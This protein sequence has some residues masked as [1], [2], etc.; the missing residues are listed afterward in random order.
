[1]KREEIKAIFSDATDEQ[2][3]AVLDLNGAD[4][5]KAKGKATALEA[6]LKEK[7]DALDSLTN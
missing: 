3:K 4:I 1:M 6:E 5:E 2:L 7:K